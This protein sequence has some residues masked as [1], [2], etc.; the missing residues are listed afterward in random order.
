MRASVLSSLVSFTGLALAVPAKRADAPEITNPIYYAP[1]DESLKAALARTSPPQHLE[2]KSADLGNGTSYPS[3][4]PGSALTPEEEQM[5]VNIIGNDDRVEVD[6]LA[7]PWS[8]IGRMASSTGALCSGALVGPRL[9][10]VARHCIDAPAGTTFT[11]APNYR[12]GPRAGESGV[13]LVA[14][15]N[16]PDYLTNNCNRKYD[17]A[18]KFS[19]AEM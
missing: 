10:S 8:T 5:H 12:D 17:W 9:V 3:S 16:V 18:C 19:L 2:L 13:N 4:H 11:F 15:L 14:Y 6:S 7:Y 1:I